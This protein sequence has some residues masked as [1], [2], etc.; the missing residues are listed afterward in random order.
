MKSAWLTC[1]GPRFHPQ[2]SESATQEACSKNLIRSQ[3]ILF[4]RAFSLLFLWKMQY[5]NA[6]WHDLYTSLQTNTLRV[7]GSL[8][9]LRMLLMPEWG[10]GSSLEL[11]NWWIWGMM[12]F[13]DTSTCMQVSPGLKL[14][15][16]AM[17]V[18]LGSKIGLMVTAVI[19]W[20]V[21]WASP[22]NGCFK[23]SHSL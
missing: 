15:E 4:S 20:K 19:S 8:V 17:L 23:K 14:R 3:R 22:S 7:Y 12:H 11:I 10:L 18:F 9:G 21:N 13:T 5:V 16:I 2:C 6:F 1:T